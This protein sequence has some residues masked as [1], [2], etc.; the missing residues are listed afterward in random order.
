M[1][2]EYEI[3][4]KKTPNNLGIVKNQHFDPQL[5]QAGKKENEVWPYRR[6][7]AVAAVSIRT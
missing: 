3:G 5:L 1:A 2:R 4:V 6:E 7:N